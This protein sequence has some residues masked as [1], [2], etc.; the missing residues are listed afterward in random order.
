MYTARDGTIEAAAL[1]RLADDDDR[2]ILDALGHTLG[3]LAALEVLRLEL[4]AVFLEF[5][6]VRLIGA[7]GLAERQQE[8]ARIARLDRHA[9]AH[10]AELVDAMHKNEVDHRRIS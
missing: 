1:T 2:H 7:N 5:F 3:L 6:Q 4:G 8:V 10:L 9:V